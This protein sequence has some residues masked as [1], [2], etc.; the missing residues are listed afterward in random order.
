MKIKELIN[1]L[2]GFID[3][4]F[5]PGT[6][7]DTIKTGSDE[8]E[9]TKVAVSM[10]ATPEVIKAAHEYGANFLIVHEP[11][12]YN[13]SDTSMPYPICYEKIELINNCGLTIFRFHDHPHTMMPDM[14]CEGQLKFS[15]LC[16]TFMKGK[17]YAVNRFILDE[18]MT[19]LELARTLEKNLGVKHLRI[20]GCRDNLVK[21]VSCCFGTPGHLEDEFAE[22]DTVLTGEI[23]EWTV[24]EYVRDYMQ[25]KNDKSMIV[26]GHINSEK[27]GMKLL[28]EM[29][30]D[31]HPELLTKYF[32]CGDLY[33]YTDG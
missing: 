22:C 4:P 15:G 25:L 18:P 23:C 3:K 32:D 20:A 33:S 2:K 5:A 8:N 14:I 30:D 24:G 19:T 29:I 10:F 6:T 16:G 31:N 12:F 27:F 11:V 1:E 28:S 7:C 17:Y 26:M 9:I 21:T 13:H